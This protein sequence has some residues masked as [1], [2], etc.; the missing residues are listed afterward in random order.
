MMETI[1]YLNEK[2]KVLV[3]MGMPVEVLKRNNIFEKIIAIKYDVPNDKLS[4]F[5]DYK[6]MI[7]D[8]YDQII[9]TNA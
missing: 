3:N 2:C 5:D 4:M 6:K 1:L 7:D 8:F 9:R